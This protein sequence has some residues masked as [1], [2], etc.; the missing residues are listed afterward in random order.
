MQYL[1][2]TKILCLTKAEYVCEGIINDEAYRQQRSR[3]PM[4]VH[5]HGDSSLIEYETIPAKYKALIIAHYG[6]PYQYASLQPLKNLVVA[7]PETRQWFADYQLPDGRNLP[8]K[9]QNKYARQ[10]DWME[11]IITA[12][13]DKQALKEIIS[14]T[15]DDFWKYVIQLHQVDQPNPELPVSKERL[16]RKV[17]A[18][19]NT[20][21]ASLIEVS[22]FLNNNAR[23]VTVEIEALLLA[24]YAERHGRATL[25]QVCQDYNAFMRGD[26]QV[27]D[28]QTG[29]AF[30]QKDFLTKGEIYPV[31]QS[32]VSY[33][34]NLTHNRELIDAIKLGSLD[35]QQKWILPNRRKPPV[36][37]F[38]KISM[39]DYLPP[40]K[41]MDGKRTVWMYVI[42]DVASLAIVGVSYG[43]KKN[44]NLVNEA[45]LDMLRL[46]LRKGWGL[47]ME[48]ELE[49]S[50]N[51][52]RRGSEEQPDI[53]TNG[54]VFPYVKFAKANNSQEKYAE[55]FLRT[56]KYEELTREEGF[57]GR[58]HGRDENFRYNKDKKEA[59][60]MV[61]TLINRLKKYVDEY[62]NQPHHTKTALTRWQYLEQQ[63]SPKAIFN[64]P[65]TII[66][67][68]GFK[69]KT[70]I[71][72]SRV[73]VQNEWYVLSDFDVRQAG[74][75]GE[76]DAYWVPG[77]DNEAP[78]RVYLYQNG[79]YVGEGVWDEPY[80]SAQAERTDRD[81]ELLGKQT[82]RQRKH[83]QRVVEGIVNMR[84]VGTMATED[85]EGIIRVEVSYDKLAEEEAEYAEISPEIPLKNDQ[86]MQ[87]NASKEG[88]FLQ[89]NDDLPSYWND[90]EAL[91]RRAISGI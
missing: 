32:T 75:V 84:Q 58:P 70:S 64:K 37:A 82:A 74:G 34:L 60:Y 56:F 24:L 52:E 42:F 43:T 61:Q 59:R 41:T 46:C 11:M 65:H 29:E 63:Q 80:Q 26:K 62:N 20:G 8:L 68:I 16:T 53:F 2:N 13:G 35:Y 67:Y 73:R 6:D 44:H 30:E 69:T 47:P 28:L 78:E 77:E 79:N 14:G 48:I 12:T 87:E 19:K 21:C 50:L 17:N 57:L 23:I 36:F 71:R 81:W 33:Y 25:R 86:N 39:D 45:L 88:G 66:P 55:G 91:K 72:R 1:P 38:S 31:E 49:R 76:V 90:A 89:E 85:A 27:F 3:N 51:W 15:M 4:K 22:R 83:E 7:K 18:Y 10:S 5:G 40:F 54:H 9:H